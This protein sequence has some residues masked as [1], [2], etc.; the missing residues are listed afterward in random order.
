MALWEIALPADGAVELV[1]STALPQR[2]EH[3]G[4]HQGS[5]EILGAYLCLENQNLMPY[6]LNVLPEGARAIPPPWSSPCP[7]HDRHPFGTS[8]AEWWRP[9]NGTA[10]WRYEDDSAG[11]IVTAGDYIRQ[12]IRRRPASQLYYGR[13]HQAVMEAGRGSGCGAGRGGLYCTEHYGPLSFSAGG[14]LKL[15][16]AGWPAGLRRRSQPA[17]RDGLHCRQSPRRQGASRRGDDPRAGPPVVGPGQH[18]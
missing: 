9:G 5:P 11:G 4:N 7:L 17:G 10:T 3:C 8:E 14:S 6:L 15:I 18:V 16:R 13:K 1:R 12:D 2:L